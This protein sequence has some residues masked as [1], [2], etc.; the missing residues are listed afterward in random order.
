MNQCI[1]VEGAYYLVIG[2]DLFK[3]R[4]SCPE[5]IQISLHERDVVGVEY[6]YTIDRLGVYRRHPQLIEK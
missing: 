1:K 6:N 3:I 2:G 4:G 5:D